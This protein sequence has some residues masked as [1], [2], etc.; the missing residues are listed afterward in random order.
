[1]FLEILLMKKLPEV[2][3]ITTKVYGLV[4]MN[5]NSELEKVVHFNT[6]SQIPFR[7]TFLPIEEF[8]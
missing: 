3:K 1:M 2:N 7:Q 4:L 6:I 5:I 8:G